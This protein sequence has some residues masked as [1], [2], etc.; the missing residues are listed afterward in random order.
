[1]TKKRTIEKKK[2]TRLKEYRKQMKE[3]LADYRK[4]VHEFNR[5]EGDTD[6]LIGLLDPRWAVQY[7]RHRNLA[8]VTEDTV[9]RHDGYNVLES[10]WGE[11][12]RKE[13]IK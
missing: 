6:E 10:Q 7:D 5:Y 12:K 8:V 2:F 13:M 11:A 1:M 3:A 4:C 9:H